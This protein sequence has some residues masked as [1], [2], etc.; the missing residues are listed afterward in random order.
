MF[1]LII[2]YD[3]LFYIELFYLIYRFFSLFSQLFTNLSGFLGGFRYISTALV[4]LF[5]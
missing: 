4:K 1:L 5:T 3:Y 2:L